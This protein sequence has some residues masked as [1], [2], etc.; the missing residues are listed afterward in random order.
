MISKVVNRGKGLCEP[1]IHFF[2]LQLPSSA[3]MEGDINWGPKRKKE[4]DYQA[5]GKLRIE[6]RE[7]K[8]SVNNTK[9]I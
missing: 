3:L 8:V 4:F 1:F 6:R 9:Y 5:R 2:Q 7:C